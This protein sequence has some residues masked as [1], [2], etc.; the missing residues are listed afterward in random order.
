M[1]YSIAVKGFKYQCFGLRQEWLYDFLK[2]GESFFNDNSLGPKQIEAL[3]YYLRDSELINNKK[4]PTH[5]YYIVRELYYREG[6]N[7]QTLWG[8]IWVNLC[9]NAPLFTWWTTLEIGSYCREE[10]LENLIVSYGKNNMSIK[11][12]FSSIRETLVKSPIGELL[13]QGIIDR[14]SRI[15]REIL[16]PGCSSLSPILILY[17]LYK[18]AEKEGIYRIE[19]QNIEDIPLS[20]QRIFAIS[21]QNL[22]RSFFKS[23]ECE[24]FYR[25]SIEDNR[26]YIYLSKDLS[27]VGILEK[28]IGRKRE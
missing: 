21:T 24:P 26:N 27:S 8:I 7:S 3:I 1:R 13:G 4:N 28:Y 10:L 5:L 9:F 22:E 16:K 25:L 14:S 23:S 18:L 19:L 20:P 17:N 11:S 15:T 6:G 12:G 2:K